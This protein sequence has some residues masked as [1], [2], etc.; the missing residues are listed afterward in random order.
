MA[1]IFRLPDA[2]CSLAKSKLGPSYKTPSNSTYQTL[3][4]SACFFSKTTDWGRLCMPRLRSQHIRSAAT[5]DAGPQSLRLNPPCHLPIVV[6]AKLIPK[7]QPLLICQLP[8]LSCRHPQYL[9]PLINAQLV[10]ILGQ[11]HGHGC[12]ICT[13][14]PGPYRT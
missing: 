2:N 13:P 14:G 5:I 1:K 8:L 7:P 10:E 4:T 6:T 12:I 9:Q 3:L 11:R